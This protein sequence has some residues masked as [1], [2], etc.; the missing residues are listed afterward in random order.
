MNENI[1]IKITMGCV[2][3]L[4]ICVTMTVVVMSIKLVVLG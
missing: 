1:F 4:A 3:V 2:S